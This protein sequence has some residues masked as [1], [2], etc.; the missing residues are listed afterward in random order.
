LVSCND[1]IVKDVKSNG[2]DIVIKALF[3][4]G[5]RGNYFS[6]KCLMTKTSGSQLI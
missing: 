4:M 6:K 5:I 1:D 2:N 3:Q